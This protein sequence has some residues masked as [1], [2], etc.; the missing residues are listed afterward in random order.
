MYRSLLVPLDGSS[1]G[2]QALPLALTLARRAGAGVVLSHVHQPVTSPYTGSELVCDLTLDTTLREHERE[3]LEQT[4]CRVTGMAGVLAT[5]V[6]LDGLVADALREQALALGADLVVL[7]THGRGPLSRFWLGSV[8]DKLVR[9]M[10]MPV[11]LVHPREGP[12]DLAADVP[13]RRI[14]VPLDGSAL[15]EQILGPA[16][17]VGRLTEAEYRLLRVIE[18]VVFPGPHRARYAPDDLDP[19]LL[20][21]LKE[22]A[23]CYLNRLADRLRERSLRVETEVTVHPSAAAAILDAAAVYGIDLIAL[24]THGRGGLARL[25]LGSVADKVVRGATVPVLVHHP[26]TP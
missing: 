22:E 19:V 4:A 8:A 10:P 5:P 18:P 14:L 11:L 7:A 25:V 16:V 15:A 23:A 24:E 9:D 13:V 2:E 3:Y 26:L 21:R 12:P 20:G 1:F 17:A 6:V